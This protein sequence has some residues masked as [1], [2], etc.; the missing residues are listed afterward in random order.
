MIR[1][2]KL[3]YMETKVYAEVK[4]TVQMGIKHKKLTAIFG[5]PGSGKSSLLDDLTVEYP[6][7][8]RIL[9]APTMT[10]KNLMV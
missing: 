4:G 1:R 7:A 10:M 6:F 8:H 9:C 5:T 2:T 3:P